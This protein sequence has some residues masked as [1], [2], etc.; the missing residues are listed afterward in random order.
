MEFLFRKMKVLEIDSGDDCTTLR[1][2]LI[3]WNCT[4]KIVK[5]VN[6]MLYIFYHN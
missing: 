2:Y 3:A 6:F 1:V 4:F 5:M